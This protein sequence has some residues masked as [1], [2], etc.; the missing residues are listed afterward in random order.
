MLVLRDGQDARP[1]GCPSGTFRQPGRCDVKV[2]FRWQ[3]RSERLSVCLHCG[4][5]VPADQEG[6]HGEWHKT[7]AA[8]GSSPES[9][10]S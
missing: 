3:R 2:G 8:N 1:S 5:C 10:Q 4:A 7:M 6:K 9:G